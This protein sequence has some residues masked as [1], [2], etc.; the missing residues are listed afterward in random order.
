MARRRRNGNG[1][2]YLLVGLMLLY[3]IF[4]DSDEGERR[5]R[6]ETLPPE[7]VVEGRVI[8]GP[9]PADPNVIVEATPP[10]NSQGTAFAISSDGLW[11]TARHVADGCQSLVLASDRGFKRYV[12]KSAVIHPRADVALL[13]TG[14]ETLP[15]KMGAAVFRKGQAGYHFGFPAGKPTAVDSRLLGR[16][17]I[18][19]QG[20]RRGRE[21]SLS[22]AEKRRVP[23][24]SGA[25]GGLS[26]GP[27]LDDEGSII[28][29]AVAASRRRGRVESAAPVSIQS[30]LKG[31]ENRLQGQGFVVN[32]Q[33]LGDVEQDLRKRGSVL[34]VFCSVG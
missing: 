21:P 5:P 19:T 11:L 24:R 15:L 3:N 30:V 27:T 16:S 31:Y 7:D 26:G 14:G 10:R 8:P 17:V 4:L 6:H 2:V 22:W 13:D 29:V 25:L 9:S 20:F 34:R 12:V 28:G 32:G 23:E 33:N 18:R 1:W